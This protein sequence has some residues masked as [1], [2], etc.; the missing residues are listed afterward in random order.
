MHLL[1]WGVFL[2]QVSNQLHQ[3][4]PICLL[5]AEL[6]WFAIWIQYVAIYHEIWVEGVL[7]KL[8]K[9][10]QVG[11]AHNSLMMVNKPLL[12]VSDGK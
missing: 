1:M 3:L 8:G 9:P 10:V 4:S 11:I 12:V 7:L 6:A 2:S 5:L